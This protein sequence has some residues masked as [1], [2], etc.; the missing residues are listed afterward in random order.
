LSTFEGKEIKEIDLSGLEDLTGKDM[1][2]LDTQ[3]RQKQKLIKLNKCFV[4]GSN[5]EIIDFDTKR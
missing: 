2:E 3:Y 4:I 1:R 5:M